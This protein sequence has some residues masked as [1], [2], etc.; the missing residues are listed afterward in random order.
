MYIK[1]KTKIHN[2]ETVFKYREHS[3]PQHQKN[4]SKIIGSLQQAKTTNPHGQRQQTHK[5]LGRAIDDAIVVSKMSY[6]P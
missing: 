2:N 6:K 4:K 1:E 5:A 3:H